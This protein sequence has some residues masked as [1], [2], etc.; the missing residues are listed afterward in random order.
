MRRIICLITLRSWNNEPGRQVRTFTVTWNVQWEPPHFK[1]LL[2]WVSTLHGYRQT[3][4]K[5]ELGNREAILLDYNSQIQQIIMALPEEL[6]MESSLPGSRTNGKHK[7]PGI[8]V[9]P[10]HPRT[11]S[12]LDLCPQILGITSIDGTSDTWSKSQ[13]KFIAL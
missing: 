3:A 9:D 1:F 8:R 4:Q 12:S 13:F 5:M 11:F 6:D 7:F 2:T 10:H